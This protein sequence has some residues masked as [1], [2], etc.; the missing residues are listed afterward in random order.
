MHYAEKYTSVLKS[1]WKLCRKTDMLSNVETGHIYVE[2]GDVTET[3]IEF[4]RRNNPCR[5][6][7]TQ[8]DSVTL[9]RKL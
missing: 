3:L 4:S 9:S 6:M 5:L 8:P 2:R 1:K 7:T